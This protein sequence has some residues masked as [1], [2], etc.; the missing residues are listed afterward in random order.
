MN[1]TYTIATKLLVF[2]AIFYGI[3]LCQLVKF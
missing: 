2:S 3:N 1:K